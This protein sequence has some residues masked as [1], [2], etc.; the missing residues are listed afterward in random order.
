MRVTLNDNNSWC[1][2][3]TEAQARTPF[4]SGSSSPFPDTVSTFPLSAYHCPAIYR[5][6][7]R[8]LLLRYWQSPYM[9]VL[10]SE[11]PGCI[12]S[13]L[14]ELFQIQPVHLQSCICLL[15]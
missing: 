1:P 15:L 8:C 5:R 10:F 2:A 3:L 4:F 9:S 7:A 12:F 14:T 13:G 6:C 11:I